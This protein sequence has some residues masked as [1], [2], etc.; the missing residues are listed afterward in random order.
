MCVNV[1]LLVYVVLDWS[2]TCICRMSRCGSWILSHKLRYR[3]LN[4][5][6]TMFN[7]KNNSNNELVK[8]VV[9]C[10]PKS[11]NYILSSNYKLWQIEQVS[12]RVST[13]FPYMH[14]LGK[15]LLNNL[16][17]CWT[18]PHFICWMHGMLAPGLMSL[19]ARFL[20]R[21]REG[22][23]KCAQTWLQPGLG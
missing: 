20:S 8:H 22:R 12:A 9:W 5:E 14:T 13:I 1:Q 2:V 17:L 4:R 15:R 18:L 6:R 16:P 3:Y 23:R 10:I 7:V 11:A 19:S 21:E